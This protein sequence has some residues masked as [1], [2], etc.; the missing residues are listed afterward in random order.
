MP[1]YIVHA[2]KAGDRRRTAP[3]VVAVAEV[4][5]AAGVGAEQS[6]GSSR[7]R[8]GRRREQGRVE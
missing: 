8:G 7:S 2:V 1:S 6:S 4:A 3:A 5:I